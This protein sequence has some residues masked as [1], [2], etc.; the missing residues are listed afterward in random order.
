MVNDL[1]SV[2]I[3]LYLNYVTGFQLILWAGHCFDLPGETNNN[4]VT[5][6]S[7]PYWVYIYIVPQLDI[8]LDNF[9]KKSFPI[10]DHASVRLPGVLHMNVGHTN[11]RC[12]IFKKS[13]HLT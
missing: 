2:K 8:K 7:V 3:D 5:S 12:V 9:S 6:R 4:D 10:W 1:S 11:L 13:Y